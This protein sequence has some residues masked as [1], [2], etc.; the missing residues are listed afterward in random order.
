MG[1]IGMIPASPFRSVYM[2][3][4]HVPGTVIH[5]SAGSTGRY[6]GC[7]SIAILEDGRYLAS[8]SYFGPGSANADS[9]VYESADDGVTWRRI[10][11]IHGQIW[12]NL[13][14]HRDALYM[15]GTDHC[16]LNGGRLNGRMVIR[17]STDGGTTWSQPADA[18][19]GLLSDH[20]GYHTAPVPVLAHGGRLWR[21]MEYAPVPDRLYWRSLV[22]SA[23]QDADLLRRANWTASEMLAHPESRTQWIEGNMVADPAGTLVNVLRTNYIGAAAAQATGYVDRAAMVRV[24]EDGMCLVHV[25]DVDIINMP[26]GGTKFTIRFDPCSRRHCALVNRQLDPVAQRNRLYLISSVDLRRW[27]TEHLLLAHLEAADHAFQSYL[28]T[29]RRSAEPWFVTPY[30]LCGPRCTPRCRWTRLSPP[31]RTRAGLRLRCPPS[32]SASWR[33]PRTRARELPAC[34]SYASAVD[35]R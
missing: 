30:P 5:H 20:D 10:A 15:M 2:T 16:D 23:P 28:T 3:F 26:G 14:V 29:L 6:I 34:W 21:S 13:F 27:D 11:E 33:Q 4:E 1:F 35:W 17:R 22:L 25:P 32:T 19:T 18:D 12:S 24:S 31:W 8:H 9:F 7:P